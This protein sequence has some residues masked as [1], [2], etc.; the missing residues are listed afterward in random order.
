[1]EIEHK[2]NCHH[3]LGSLSDYLDGDLESQ[4]CAELESHLT[5]CEK[6]RVVV[7]TLRRTVSLYHIEEPDSTLP[8]GVRERLLHRLNLDEYI[9]R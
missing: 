3:L 2:G 6:C 5:G 1:M 4:V 9:Q 8:S 7:D